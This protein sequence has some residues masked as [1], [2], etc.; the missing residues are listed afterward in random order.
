MTAW[1]KSW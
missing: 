1:Q